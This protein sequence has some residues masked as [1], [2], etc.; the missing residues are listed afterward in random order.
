[1]YEY[2]SK[3]TQVEVTIMGGRQSGEMFSSEDQEP[4]ISKSPKFKLCNTERE[5][6]MNYLNILFVIKY[7]LITI[8]SLISYF[9]FNR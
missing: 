3:N 2:S 5:I 4:K 9:I 6:T 1:M 7:T 8:I